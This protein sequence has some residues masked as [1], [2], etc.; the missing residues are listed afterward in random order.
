[1]ITT[2]KLK[3][4]TTKVTVNGVTT[5]EP[6]SQEE[7]SARPRVDELKK[8]LWHPPVSKPWWFLKKGRGIVSEEIN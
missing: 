5:I 7:L 6:T 2:F 4:N 8:Y 1:M 3:N